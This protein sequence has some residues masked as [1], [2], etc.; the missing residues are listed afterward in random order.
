MMTRDEQIQM[1]RECIDDAYKTT[2][3]PRHIPVYYDSAEIRIA[4]T[5]FQYRTGQKVVAQHRELLTGLKETVDELTE[6]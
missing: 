5:F 3:E 1:M 6:P 4:I 2:S